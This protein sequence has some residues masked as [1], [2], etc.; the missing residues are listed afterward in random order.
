MAARVGIGIEG[1]EGFWPDDENRIVIDAAIVFA[2][3]TH[4]VA[5]V[6][7][8]PADKHRRQQLVGVSL[9]PHFYG[10]GDYGELLGPRFHFSAITSIA[11]RIV[12]ASTVA[13]FEPSALMRSVQLVITATV[14]QI[15][16]AM[17]S[18]AIRLLVSG[19]GISVLM[20]RRGRFVFPRCRCSCGRWSARCRAGR[21]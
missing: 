20:A 8:N 5:V 7:A 10:G 12:G 2:F 14:A 19:L 13:S 18:H 17:I 16:M 1:G 15:S 11:R 9:H 4:G 21:G 3:G 6:A